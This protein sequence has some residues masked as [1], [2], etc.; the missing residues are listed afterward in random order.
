LRVKLWGT[1][2]SIPTPGSGPAF[3]GNT[4]CVQVTCDDGSE[5]VLDA[6]TGIRVLGAALARHSGQLHVLLTHLHLDHIQGLLFFAPFFDPR[7]EITVWGPPGWKRSLR[8]RLARYLSSP[9]SAVEIRDLPARVRFEDAP[10]GP[11]RLGA[12]EIHAELVSH[13]G[14][15]LGYRL[16]AGGVSLCYLPDH[17]P[18][19]G[20]DLVSTPA[21]WISGL[22][23]AAGATVLVHDCQYF[24]EEYGER[25]GWGHSRLA[26]ALAF[27]RRAEAERTLL[28]HHDPDHDDVALGMMLAE[29]RGRWDGGP[30]GGSVDLAREGDELLLRA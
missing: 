20:V 30:N 11:W 6:G 19:L 14:P 4:S 23:L 8:E 5:L 18:G 21:S 15:T 29:A 26:D 2:G 25:M 10:P 7:A 22:E 9:L 16:E 17:E 3:G 24:D 12:C 1:R 28:F 13:R 27:A